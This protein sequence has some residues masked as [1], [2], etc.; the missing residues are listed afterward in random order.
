MR[1]LLTIQLLTNL[2][3]L[4]SLFPRQPNFPIFPSFQV[5]LYESELNCFCI[6]AIG[7]SDNPCSNTFHGEYAFSEPEAAAVADYIS[8]DAEEYDVYWTLHTYGQLWM[9]PFGYTAE[10]PEDNDEVVSGIK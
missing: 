7:S 6:P 5:P 1:W 3:T 4:G 10:P 2:T 8:Q 9:S